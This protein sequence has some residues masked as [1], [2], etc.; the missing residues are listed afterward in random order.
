ME[1]QRA[2]RHKR[3]AV[4]SSSAMTN[5][6]N[7][8]CGRNGS[9]ERCT[10]SSVPLSASKGRVGGSKGSPARHQQ[11][12][13]GRGSPRYPS[14]NQQLFA[15]AKWTEPPAATALPTPPVHWTQGFMTL[16]RNVSVGRACSGLH[17]ANLAAVRKPLLKSQA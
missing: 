8:M 7:K 12:A 6:I 11:Q 2:R 9:A 14:P 3:I 17:E 15:G 4:S 10:V 13:S 16:A 5:T 1:S